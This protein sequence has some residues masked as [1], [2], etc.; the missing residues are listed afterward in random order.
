M[1]TQAT[2]VKGRGDDVFEG[3]TQRVTLLDYFTI[4]VCVQHEVCN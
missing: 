4:Q 3:F 2:L 1:F